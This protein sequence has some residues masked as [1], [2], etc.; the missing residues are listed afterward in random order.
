MD[1]DEDMSCYDLQEQMLEI[2]YAEQSELIP[3]R[4][5]NLFLNYVLD[6]KYYDSFHFSFDTKKYILRNNT[7]NCLYLINV[8]ERKI[9]IF[10]FKY[11]RD[12]IEQQIHVKEE[13]YSFFHLQMDAF[14]NY[15]IVNM[16]C[17][18]EIYKFKSLLSVLEEHGVHIHSIDDSKKK[19][20][21]SVINNQLGDVSDIII[22]RKL[23]L[24]R[25][26]FKFTFT[27]SNEI[28]KTYEDCT[29]C[30][31][32]AS[33]DLP[34][35]QSVLEQKDASMEPFSRKELQDIILYFDHVN[36]AIP[37]VI[38]VIANAIFYSKY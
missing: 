9:T 26:I 35:Y 3:E 2:I 25:H 27:V 16:E 12:G 13:F 37:E 11:F 30:V 34:F 36:E 32:L 7:G 4:Y 33:R 29:A 38:F 22:G 15:A 6:V 18:F 1:I 28:C 14:L 5:F 21:Y 20:I 24:H 8:I 31:W 23:Y 10:T 17:D 19:A